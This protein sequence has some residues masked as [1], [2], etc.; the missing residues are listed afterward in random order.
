MA[1]NGS[2]NFHVEYMD[3]VQHWHSESQPFAGGDSLLTALYDGWEMSDIVVREEYWFAGMR[4]VKVYHFELSRGDEIM[5]MPIID[6]PYLTRI[7]QSS[8]L[9]VM[10]SEDYRHGREKST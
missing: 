3:V 5:V 8:Q 7:I 2:T 4:S 9:Q 10:S 1:K 6:T